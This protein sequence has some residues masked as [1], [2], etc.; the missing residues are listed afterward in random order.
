MILNGLPWKRKEIILSFLRLHP[1]TR[2]IQVGIRHHASNSSQEKSIF[3]KMEST[4]PQQDGRKPLCCSGR[5]LGF[6]SRKMA[7]P[8]LLKFLRLLKTTTTTTTTKDSK[9][10]L[11]AL[12]RK[13]HLSSSLAPKC[14]ASRHLVI[15]FWKAVGIQLLRPH[16][17]KP[18]PWGSNIDFSTH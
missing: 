2:F 17:L 11:L 5:S 8:K 16:T 14:L 1:S 7:W 10:R 18:G 13:G 4:S 6:L 12:H 3:W 15:S 9:T